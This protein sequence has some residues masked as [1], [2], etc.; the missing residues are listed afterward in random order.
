MVCLPSFA[1]R[2]T[3]SVDWATKEG[4][5]CLSKEWV[6]SQ[7]GSKA[8]PQNR[9]RRSKNPIPHRRTAPENRRPR[10]G[11][12]REAIASFTILREMRVSFSA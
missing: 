8:I 1:I 11:V 9:S 2:V 3:Q 5:A 10:F 6:L 7:A 12:L 4:M